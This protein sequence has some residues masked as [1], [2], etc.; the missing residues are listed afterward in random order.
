M[1]LLPYRFTLFSNQGDNKITGFQFYY[2]IDLH[3]SQTAV[4]LPFLFSLFYYLID[5]HYSQTD[6]KIYNKIN[7]FYYLIDLHYSQTTWS[8]ITALLLFYYLIDLHYSQTRRGCPFLSDC[9]LLPYRFTLFSNL[10]I[11]C[12]PFCL[13]LLPYRFTLFS[14]GIWEYMRSNEFYYLIDLH[15]SQTSNWE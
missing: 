11:Y 6:Y 9:V 7:M 5:L 15:Y 12:K 10:Y 3:Y 4:F 8:I 13:V 14:N 2:L 1:V